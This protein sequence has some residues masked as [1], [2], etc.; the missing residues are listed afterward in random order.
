MKTIANELRNEL[1]AAHIIIRNALGVA[2]FDQ[3]IAWGN[4]NERD[5]VIG[6]GTTRAYERQAAIDGGD[7]DRLYCELRNADR[8]IANAAALLSAH[9]WDLWAVAN[10]QAGAALSHPT[11]DDLRAALLDRAALGWSV[12][13]IGMDVG[14]A[15]GHQTA[16]VLKPIGE[17]SAADM[18]VLWRV[19]E[20]GPQ[21]VRIMTA[22]DEFDMHAF[23]RRQRAFSECTFGPGRLTARVCDHIRKELTEVEAAPDDLR[24]WIDVIM[25]GLD[26]AWRTGAT[27]EQITAALSAKMTTNEGRTWPDW[28]TCDPDRAIEH[29]AGG[30][31]HAT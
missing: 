31:A 11:R 14:N 9:Q 27:P 12:G 18:A 21:I 7:A 15:R 24:E 29:I 23:L 20:S 30:D 6:E 28:R 17:L 26:G 8:I 16:V 10:R 5:D 1:R 4:A 19:L 22:A 3:K 13:K 25:L 2:T